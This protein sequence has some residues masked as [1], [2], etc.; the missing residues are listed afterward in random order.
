MANYPIK[1]LKDEQ[2]T[3]F[4]P[5]VSTQAVRNPD[6]KTVEDILA[7]KLSPENI[8]AGE[9]IIVTQSGSDV[10]ITA[11]VPDTTVLIDNLST[12]TAG[13]GALDARQGNVL[14][15]AIPDV[16]D[17]LNSQST[18]DALSANQGYILNNRVAPLEEDLEGVKDS[19]KTLNGNNELDIEDAVEA[20]TVEYKVE[21]KCEQEVTTKYNLITKGGFSTPTSEQNYYGSIGFAFTPEFDGWCK[22]SAGSS[23]HNQFSNS[24][25]KVE[26]IE[27]QPSTQYTLF[28]EVK[29]LTGGIRLQTGGGTDHMFTTDQTIDS[30]GISKLLV[31][32]KADLTNTVLRFFV[33]FMNTTNAGSIEY[34]MMILEGDHRS[35]DLAYKPY[36]YNAPTPEGKSEVKTLPSI[37][38]L[39]DCSKE[40]DIL[41]ASEEENISTG[42]RVIYTSTNSDDNTNARYVIGDM[43][44]YAGKIITMSAIAKSSSSNPAFCY[45]RLCDKDGNFSN[46]YGVWGSSTTLNGRVA[47]RMQL[48]YELDSTYHYLSLALYSSRMHVASIGDYVDYTDIMISEGY[49]LQ[50]YV[51]YGYYLKIK[52]IGKNL[53]NFVDYFYKANATR[54]TRQLVDNGIKINFTAGQDAWL[55]EAYIKGSVDKGNISKIAIPVKADTKYTVSGSGFPKCYITHLDKDYNPLNTDYQ[56]ITAST[57]QSSYTFT[58]LP[59]TAYIALRLGISSND[60]TEWT[61]SNLQLEESEAVTSYEPY[62]ERKV[63]IDLSK[64][65]LFTNDE[66]NYWVNGNQDY[67]AVL[68]KISNGIRATVTNSS[69]QYKYGGYLIDSDKMLG[70]TF[71]I[72]CNV[73]PSASNNGFVN[74]YWHN[75]TTITTQIKEL[76]AQGGTFTIPNTATSSKVAILFYGNRN[77]TGNIGDYVD[78]TDIRLFEGTGSTPYYELCKIGDYKDTLSINSGGNVVVNKNIGKLIL[79]GGESWNSANTNTFTTTKPNNMISNGVVISDYFVNQQAASKNAIWISNTLINITNLTTSTLNDFKTWLG[80]HNTGVYYVLTTPETITLPNTYIPLFKGINHIYLIDDLETQTEIKYYSENAFSDIYYTKQETDDH[81]KDL[82][83]EGGQSGQVLMQDANGELTWGDAADPNAIVGDGS[84]KKIV[85]MTYEEYKALDSVDPDTEYHILDAASSLDD[86]QEILNSLQEQINTIQRNNKVTIITAS[87]TKAITDTM[88]PVSIDAS[89]SNN[90]NTNLVVTNNGIKIGPGV[91]HV[92]V[93]LSHRYDWDAPINHYFYECILVNGSVDW[94]TQGATHRTEQIQYTG[95]VGPIFMNVSENDLLQIGASVESGS[96]TVNTTCTYR[97]TVQVID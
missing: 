15:N 83:P 52:N 48:P 37:F 42:K 62:K 70:K 45:L 69:G 22:Q 13:Q 19:L 11:D 86:L 23:S 56:R 21:G 16:E 46:T 96:S 36:T 61:F 27:V 93:S 51:P 4:V 64:E 2:G 60:Y 20:N 71:T 18:D 91:H 34:R 87:G 68:S 26:N 72:S 31:T 88:S 49:Y 8:K 12:T 7:A 43:K 73:V 55:G 40:A 66:E 17:S 3:P 80:A 6:G 94:S 81:I 32:T 54:C 39:Y 85:E 33:N 10:T 29:N 35:E 78:Y 14:L 59:N 38:N 76:T 5:L 90:T 41:V 79:S 9:N 53:Y 24:Y 44:D 57:T 1:M 77:G 47:I 97:L 25:I 28:I 95:S 67:R 82:I 92:L 75:G 74:I 84:I 50:E 30:N 63:L 58:T 65:N 89:S